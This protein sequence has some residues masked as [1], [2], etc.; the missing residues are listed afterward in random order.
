MNNESGEIYKNIILKYIN[1]VKKSKMQNQ[2][3][4][5]LLLENIIR[6]ELGRLHC[7]LKGNIYRLLERIDFMN[8]DIKIGNL[9]TEPEL[10]YT[11]GGTPYCIFTIVVKKRY[12][13]K[14]EEWQEDKKY[15]VVRVWRGQAKA[16]AKHLKVGSLVAVEGK[17]VIE[18]NKANN[19]TYKNPLIDAGNV[20]FLDWLVNKN[21]MKERFN[22]VEKETA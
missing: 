8:I 21:I 7:K 9:V 13:D 16:C 15:F 18:E 6:E 12:K 19:T 22:L 10:A 3:K 14:N 17:S 20:E 1:L 11:N 5:E 2:W 4:R